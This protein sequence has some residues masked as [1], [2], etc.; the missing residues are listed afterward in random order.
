MAD[1]LEG[2]A[3][4]RSLA[5]ESAEVHAIEHR[6][7]EIRDR[8]LAEEEASVPRDQPAIAECLDRCA[9]HRLTKGNKSEAIRLF[10]RALHI[11]KSV[12]GEVHFNVA[13]SITILAGACSFRDHNNARTAELWK[14]AVE[15]LE[16]LYE[17]P[18]TRT[19]NVV[20]SLT[21]NLE[22]LAMRAFAKD[23]FDAAESLFRRVVHLNTQFFGKER[24]AQPLNSPAF[25]HILMHRSEFGEAESILKASNNVTHMAAARKRVLIELYEATG[26]YEDAESLKRESQ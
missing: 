26:R 8:L 9:F 12:F 19:A 20:S 14:D 7:S 3:T 17:D 21:G 15:I 18:D 25:A 5:D 22:N 11:R 4:A 24:C 16:R 2:L 10:E 6:A 23:D 1:S 13:N